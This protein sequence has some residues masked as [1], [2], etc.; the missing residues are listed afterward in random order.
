MT[1]QLKQLVIIGTFL[2]AGLLVVSFWSPVTVRAQ[3]SEPG[4]PEKS[5]PAPPGAPGIK[6]EDFIKHFDKMLQNQKL[7][8]EATGVFQGLRGIMEGAAKGQDPRVL[9]EK[10]GSL[11]QGLKPFIEQPGLPPAVAN[12]VKSFE[13][14]TKP[15]N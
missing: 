13:R 10:S 15:G 1:R 5:L 8:S 4:L 14:M 6:P 12:M 7:P 2:V 9:R 11:L 3:G